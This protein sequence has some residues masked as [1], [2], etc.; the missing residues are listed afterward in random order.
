MTTGHARFVPVLL[1]LLEK[2]AAVE[3]IR[4]YRGRRFGA[5]SIYQLRFKPK[6]TSNTVPAHE[7]MVAALTS[8]LARGLGVANPKTGQRTGNSGRFTGTTFS[9]DGLQFEV[10]LGRGNDANRGISFEQEVLEALKTAV[11]GNQSELGERVLLALALADRS[12][13]LSELKTVEA[14]TGSTLR[15]AVATP[16]EAGQVLA[17]IVLTLKDGSRRFLS[18][19]SATG[20]TI[21]QLGLKGL[22]GP[23]LKPDTSSWQWKTLV[24]PFGVAADR[25]T[26]GLQAYGIRDIGPAV[27]TCSLPIQRGTTAYQALCLMW[28]T[29]YIL[30]KPKGTKLE[31][32]T[33]D[34]NKLDSD[35]LKDL[36]VV[37]VR[38]PNFS[39]K[40]VTVVLHGPRHRYKLEVRNAKGGLAPEQVQLRVLSPKD[41]A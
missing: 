15:Q 16:V 7:R 37:E 30:L 11:A 24:E 26:E 27:D 25:V 1:H 21:G 9:L 5:T 39:R 34:Q 32:F 29:D 10:L 3:E 28:G 33:V 17:D 23:D 8:E 19:K 20:N 18:I 40:Q 41:N 4:S 13:R 6:K 36:A 2:T 12:I 22:F 31:A 14:R 38:Y 35:L